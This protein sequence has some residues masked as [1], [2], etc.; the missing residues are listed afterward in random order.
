MTVTLVAGAAFALTGGDLAAAHQPA[1]DAAPSILDW[2]KANLPAILGV[3]LAISE[4]LSVTP[5]FQGNG[6]LDSIV[7][8]LKFLTSK[9]STGNQ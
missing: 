4:A 2:F 5:W 1:V 3:A 7:K 8:S 6:I 9:Q